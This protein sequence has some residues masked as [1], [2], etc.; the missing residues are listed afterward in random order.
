MYN[1][2][3]KSCMCQANYN[4]NKAIE[5]A[6]STTNIE[7]DNF[8]DKPCSCCFQDIDTSIGCSCGF[9]ESINVFPN[10]P[11]LAQSYVPMQY[12]G[13]TFTPCCGLKMG[14]IFP[15]LVSPYNP[16]QSMEEIAY[17]KSRNEIGEGC[18]N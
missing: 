13:K 15:E 7:G 3:N 12:I 18:N 10:N 5:T 1:G 17:L 16:G 9:D 4:N 6:C 2:Y 11:M 8:E 14:T